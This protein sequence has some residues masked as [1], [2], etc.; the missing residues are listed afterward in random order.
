MLSMAGPT[1]AVSWG[2]W[3]WGDAGG[4]WPQEKLHWR[5][6]PPI[7]LKVA[8]LGSHC[9]SCACR[10]RLPVLVGEAEEEPLERKRLELSSKD[11][12]RTRAM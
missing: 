6:L 9:K 11:Q 3:Q 4:G 5:S 1:C 8:V 12:V 10:I 7:C 2:P